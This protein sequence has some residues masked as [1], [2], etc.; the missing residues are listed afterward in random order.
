MIS[1]PEISVI[2]STYNEKKKYLIEAIESIR[3]QTFRDFEFLI[4]LDN[5]QNEEIRG[6]VYEYASKDQRIRVI[7]N[8]KNI[9]LTRSLNK[10][11]GVAK[12]KYMSRMDADD[13]MV[14]TCLE[15]EI[16][17]I[18]E[19]N[20]DLVA[21]SKKNIDEKGKVLGVFVNDFSPEQMK[22]LLPYDNSINHPT[23]LVRMEILRKLKGYREIHSCEDYDLWIRMLCYGCRMR[24]LPDIFL[25]RRMRSE[26]ICSSNAYQL[27]CSK[28]FVM[29]LYKKGKKNLL[30]LEDLTKYEEY[31]IK[32]ESVMRQKRFNEAYKILYDGINFWKKRDL[33]RFL[34]CIWKALMQDRTMVDIILDKM[35]YQIRRHIFIR[36]VH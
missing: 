23:V 30:L 5:P 18:K 15:R 11:I 19:D 16:Q 26:G 12:G 22:W 17:V 20:L 13:I 35:L 33:K 27:Y 2:M 9:G 14:A 24:I 8:E 1:V 34:D 7:E 3:N 10:A 29:A 4:V 21:A 32:L 28:R 31:M 36:V 6:C 25:L